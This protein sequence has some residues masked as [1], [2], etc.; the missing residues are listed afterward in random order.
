MKDKETGLTLATSVYES[1]RHDIMN[2]GIKP[3]DKLTF[4]ALRDKYSIGISPLREALNRL[5]SEGWVEREEQKGFRAA[6]ISELELRELVR[7]RILVEGAAITE[8]IKLADVAYEES[9]V[10]AFHRLKKEKRLVDGQR[11]I[12]WEKCHRDFHIA[13]VAGAKLPHVTA[14]ATQLFD[15]AERYR[16]LCASGYPER[17]ERDEH[18]EIVDAYLQAD[19][20]RTLALLAAHY[21]VTVD[22]IVKASFS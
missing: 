1:I 6:E 9:L 3:G 18:A 11:S 13:L 12:A 16:I 19:A 10:L 7:S 15:I 21:Q 5:H 8:A 4:D 22:M 14:F 20:P 2:G 17:N